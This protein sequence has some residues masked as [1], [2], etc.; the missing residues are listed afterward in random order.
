MKIGDKIFC[1][2]CA[3]VSGEIGD[4]IKFC[5]KCGIRM[6]VLKCNKCGRSVVNKDCRRCGYCGDD[7]KETSN[8][9]KSEG[10]GFDY[11]ES[12]RRETW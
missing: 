10:L 3:D 6:V 2:R 9:D 1:P 8:N 11:I 7:P 5:H 12:A 4:G